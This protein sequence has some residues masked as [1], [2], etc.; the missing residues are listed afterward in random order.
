MNTAIKNETSKVNS[1][2]F[3]N[4]CLNTNMAQ[5]D[6]HFAKF[7]KFARSQPEAI[8]S[9]LSEIIPPLLCHL[10]IEMLKGRDWRPAIDFLRKHAPL[11]GKV[12][13][14]TATAQPTSSS[15]LLLLN[16]QKINGTIDGSQLPGAEH[17]SMSPAAHALVQNSAIVFAP[18]GRPSTDSARRTEPYKQLIQKLSQI[19]RIQD[20][21]CEPLVVQFRS[22][23]SQLRLRLVS[24]AAMRQYLA[25]HGHSLILQTL[26]TWFYFD[27][28]DDKNFV[29]LSPDATVADVGV[30]PNTNGRGPLAA[31]P[32]ASTNGQLNGSC[33]STP[34]EVDDG[35]GDTP[36]SAVRYEH[37][38]DFT[39]HSEQE[40]ERY[41][42]QN[43]FT[44][45]YVRY[46]MS[47]AE[48]GLPRMGDDRLGSGCFDERAE[49]DDEEGM[50]EAK[51]EPP[52]PQHTMEDSGL[53]G[54]FP[55][56]SSEER[57]RRLKESAT[58]LSL[59]QR[60]LCVYSLDNVGHLLTSVA[61]D[62][63]CCHVASGFEDSTIMLWSTS[64]STQLGRKPY[65]CVRDRQC[66][67]NVTSCDS[68]FSESEDSDD[69]EGDEG[70]R[71]SGSGY[72]D[73]TSLLDD[74]FDS[75]TP[76]GGVALRG[77][78][79]AVT[80][81]L[82]SEQNPLLMS[83]SRDCTMRA[84][85]GSD[86]TCRAIYRGHNHPIWCV[87][88]SSTG[89]YLATG[90]RDTTARLWSTDRRFPLQMY[91]GHT[92][93]V[94]TVA[95]H[96]NGNYLATGSTDLSVRLW[97]V[98][99]GK[100]FRI[101]TDCRLPVHRI[102]F[103]PDGKYL[104]AGGEE[105][106]VRIFDLA[107][108]SQ[109][110]ELKDHTAPVTCVTWST[111]S[112]HFVS[113]CADGTIRIWDAKRMLLTPASSSMPTAQAAV[114]REQTPSSSLS[115]NATSASRSGVSPGGAANTLNNGTA[116]ASMS[117]PKMN[118]T[119]H[120]PGSRAHLSAANDPS[121][122]PAAS[123]STSS[124]TSG[125][126]AGANS[127]NLLLAYSTGLVARAGLE[128]GPQNS[129]VGAAAVMGDGGPRFG[130]YMQSSQQTT[131]IMVVQQHRHFQ[132]QCRICGVTEGLR[133]C[134]RCQI[135]YY[136]SVD[137][138]R[139]DWKV[140]KI[141]C[142]SIHQLPPAQPVTAD[143]Q[144]L[145]YSSAIYPNG[146]V[147]QAQEQRQLG[148]SVNTQALPVVALPNGGNFCVRAEMQPPSGGTPA[149]T[150]TN[151]AFVPNVNIG[152]EASLPQ[153]CVNPF[154]AAEETTT[155]A[156][157]TRAQQQ[158]Q[159]SMVIPSEDGSDSGDEFL[160]ELAVA[161]LFPID[162]LASAEELADLDQ[163]DVDH[164]LN[165]NNFLNNINNLNV[166][167][168]TEHQQQEAQFTGIR[169]DNNN[170]GFPIDD[171][172]VL[173]NNNNNS[174]VNGTLLVDGFDSTNVQQVVF[175]PSKMAS[176]DGPLLS[177][178]VTPGGDSA[179]AV[180][181]LLGAKM[182][183]MRG[184][185]SGTVGGN[186]S[187]TTR[188]SVD[189]TGAGVATPASADGTGAVD[190]DSESLDEACR[191]LIRDMN[192]YGVC[193]LDNFLGQELGQ[194][195]LEEVTGM[196]SSGVFRDGQL[197]SNRGGKNL[198]H[199][200]GDKITW[201]GGKEPGCSSIGHLI[202]RVDAVI[203]NCKRMKNNGKLG[204][205]NIKERTKAVSRDF[206]SDAYVSSHVHAQILS[207]AENHRNE[208]AE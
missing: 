141:E 16:Q 153:P 39:E 168:G 166:F 194:Q 189:L 24:I 110:T 204:R 77:H 23:R 18:S 165:E 133:R 72:R 98:T 185:S 90:S 17:G 181:A 127:N 178:M 27:T 139:I 202:N 148:S 64:R 179:S 57:L 160:N 132:H 173:N 30:R 95:F 100:L 154:T 193:V 142:R 203:T 55:R 146:E 80:D 13:P 188:M 86:Y 208:R 196:Y 85:T 45:H 104:A 42:L 161:K 172:T 102:C 156:T 49:D 7:V 91:V 3:S 144:Q 125:S 117:N 61:I 207:G 200:R 174:F 11:V 48:N 38:Y 31:V 112:R 182:D 149:I 56:I 76:T 67:W 163:I 88:E 192:E 197:V 43:G 78:S 109:L 116:T 97:C 10:Y 6:Q 87:T 180:N 150:T 8:R 206:A 131:P 118:I 159:P 70:R 114:P 106:R 103:S 22:C 62:P 53:E 183:S 121:G 137:H 111:D 14:P 68:R 65:A 101:F 96:P 83:V 123:P 126:H 115:A 171:T 113:S 60:P 120:S 143:Q 82:F 122:G 50:M 20:C 140:H 47:E 158:Q 93:D 32:V 190:L 176:V 71:A 155:T 157:I 169:V 105:N 12:E 29:D 130:N 134:S 201:I 198:R 25:K 5:V 15:P 46:K 79:N 4:I 145:A 26:R 63:G 152:S 74:G 40:N 129:S 58:K 59:Y 191:S 37:E 34:M 99:S 147:R 75:I 94:D 69:E 36:G 136:C 108:G 167:D 21:E 9:E 138:Q 81:L 28:A 135:A 35:G 175:D 92:Q 164:I 54:M 66:S 162:A 170:Q 51:T 84:W 187:I 205:Y 107:A 186:G 33:S 177:K 41:L 128:G 44:T 151:G 195:V 19:T 184:L 1:F 2:L 52:I 89:L 199:I 119:T 124:P 73:G